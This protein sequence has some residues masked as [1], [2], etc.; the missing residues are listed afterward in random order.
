MRDA[1]VVPRRSGPGG[2]MTRA[3]GIEPRVQLQTAPMRFI[4]REL[5]RIVV[6]VRGASHLTRQILRPRLVRRWVKGI[7]SRPNL[8][9]HGVESELHGAVEDV[10]QLLLLLPRRQPRFR[11]PVDILDRRYPDASEFVPN[12]RRGCQVLYGIYGRLSPRSVETA[13]H[14]K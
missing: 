7:G 1:D 9:N 11:R 3:V 8:E 14:E 5:E 6:R 13:E 12:W 2:R 10:E 4:D